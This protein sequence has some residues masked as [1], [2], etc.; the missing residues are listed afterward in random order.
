MAVL[1]PKQW[2]TWLGVW[3]AVANIHRKGGGGGNKKEY[4]TKVSHNSIGDRK[5]NMDSRDRCGTLD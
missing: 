2:E 1:E 5:Q 4:N 3:Q